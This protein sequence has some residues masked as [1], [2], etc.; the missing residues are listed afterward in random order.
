MGVERAVTR[1]YVQRQAILNEIAQLEVVQLPQPAR[2]ETETGKESD[3]LSTFS[4]SDPLPQ[5]AAAEVPQDSNGEDLQLR[6]SQARE[7]LKSLGPC[8]RPMMG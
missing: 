4:A 1:W 2:V 5:P 8:P 3:A 7:R 6:L